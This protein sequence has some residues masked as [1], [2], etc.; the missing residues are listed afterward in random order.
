MP[1]LSS[2]ASLIAFVTLH[3]F[4]EPVVVLRT[5]AYPLNLSGALY[6]LFLNDQL[7]V[8][9]SSLSSSKYQ[10]I[11]LQASSVLQAKYMIFA[12]HCRQSP[13]SSYFRITDM[14]DSVQLAIFRFG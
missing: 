1:T 7:T 12:F 2:S 4:L 13:S 5:A 6:N 8:H 11:P 14:T 9:L 10:F 3:Y